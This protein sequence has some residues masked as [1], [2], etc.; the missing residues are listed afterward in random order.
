[1][2]KLNYHEL[3]KEL[4]GW[5]AE[6]GDAWKSNWPGWQQYRSSND[7]FACE[8]CEEDC[9]E[10]PI[11]WVGNENYAFSYGDRQCCASGSL[12]EEWDT[13]KTT[14]ERKKLAAQIRDL[15]WKE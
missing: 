13:S 14:Y 8:A 7:C 15:P 3:H 1:M 5:L 11:D 6:T 2:P 9:S 10:C 4:W 12:Y